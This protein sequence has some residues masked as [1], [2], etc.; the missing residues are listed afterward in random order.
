MSKR[1]NSEVQTLYVTT[2]EAHEDIPTPQ[3]FYDCH[4]LP[5]RPVVIRH[6]SGALLHN[7]SIL[8][9]LSSGEKLIEL[10]GSEDSQTAI[11]VNVASN[12]SA[13]LRNSN[14]RRN[15]NHQVPI[16]QNRILIGGYLERK[17]NP[18]YHCIQDGSVQLNMEEAFRYIK[19]SKDD[20][21]ITSKELASLVGA[22][23]P[24][25]VLAVKLAVE[26]LREDCRIYLN[27]GKWFP[28]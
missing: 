10:L 27:Q 16:P 25:E 23:E 15:I 17:L 3:K 6:R 21:G 8:T 13:Q 5:R 1:S 11:E 4:V 12:V 28:M 7:P 2:L 18:L 20:G 9:E 26:R 22:V 14:F 19:H 24:N